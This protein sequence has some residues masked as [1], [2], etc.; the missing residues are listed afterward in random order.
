MLG[1]LKDLGYVPQVDVLGDVV[2]EEVGEDVALGDAQPGLR[3]TAERTLV[4]SLT[5]MDY[6]VVVEQTERVVVQSTLELTDGPLGYIP[7]AANST[8]PN[9]VAQ[10]IKDG[11]SF[12]SRQWLTV[13]SPWPHFTKFFQFFRY[14][15]SFLIWGNSA[16]GSS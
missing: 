7:L 1:I 15:R 3:L 8:R 14:R 2:G 6:D 10:P 16:P 13:G 11:Q 5:P 9:T 12:E 4:R